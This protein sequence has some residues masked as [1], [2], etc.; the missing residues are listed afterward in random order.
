MSQPWPPPPDRE[1]I[2][3]LIRE[4]DIEGLIEINSAPADEYDGEADSLLAVIRNASAAELTAIHLQPTL[5]KIFGKSFNLDES[6]LA[7][8]RPALV[9]LAKQIERFFGPEAKPHVR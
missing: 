4:A 9:G 8:R 5:E 7:Q 2:R 3:Q 6:E 1:S